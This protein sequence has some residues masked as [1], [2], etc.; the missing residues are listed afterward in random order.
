MYF[1]YVDHAEPAIQA[2]L[3]QAKDLVYAADYVDAELSPATNWL[4]EFQAFVA[5][6]Q[7]GNVTA[8]GSVRK[9]AFNDQLGLFLT[10][11]VY[12]VLSSVA[13]I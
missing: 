8:D 3:L 5:R 1:R 6:N 12:D 13:V 7:P 9:A 4:K 2:K 10:Q 11:Q